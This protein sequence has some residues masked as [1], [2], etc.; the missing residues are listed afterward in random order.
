[1]VKQL[2]SG[3]GG[4]ARSG[5]GWWI[6]LTDMGVASYY[7]PRNDRHRV[8]GPWGT[9][10]FLSPDML[11]LDEERPVPSSF[12]QA[13]KADIWAVGITLLV[14][15]ARGLPLWRS[16]S[17]AEVLGLYKK[18]L[19]PIP[20]HPLTDANLSLEARR[21]LQF[22]VQPHVAIRPTADQA[23]AHE[24][25]RPRRGPIPFLRE[26]YTFYLEHQPIL[27]MF[28]SFDQ[29]YLI[30]VTKHQVTL[31]PV[32]PGNAEV[33]FQ[34][35]GKIVV[36][37]PLLVGIL[38]LFEAS[39]TI[40]R[41]HVLSRTVV[42]TVQVKPLNASNTY[43]IAA[44]PTFTRLAI[45]RD[46]QLTLIT[47]TETKSSP[48]KGGL[49]TIMDS[50]ILGVQFLKTDATPT[51]DQLIVATQTALHYLP[52]STIPD[53]RT[54]LLDDE[55]AVP[56][57]TITGAPNNISL[58]PDGDVITMTTSD[59]KTWTTRA[60]WGCWRRGEQVAAGS[61]VS[62]SKPGM[63]AVVKGVQVAVVKGRGWGDVVTIKEDDVAP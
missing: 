41:I 39:G 50:P 58:A 6:K 2:P 53:D 61:I 54:I 63:M 8:P 33:I 45:A 40:T 5:D 13:Q 31:V 59:G 57:P 17:D 37:A 46:G 49:H 3:T 51:T 38:T 23:L 25:M 16:A 12:E 18:Y 4:P 22:L 60:A 20:D 29:T 15:A 30:V 21:F 26:L 43:H 24:W 28:F 55:R 56:Y 10:P 48:I 34:A 1:M 32:V 9:V 44:S 7:H 14:T 35:I 62:G 52:L 47:T 19:A 27:E 11:R 36:V 42:D